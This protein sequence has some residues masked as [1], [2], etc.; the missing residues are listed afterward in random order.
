MKGG[1]TVSSRYITIQKLAED[2]GIDP[3]SIQAMLRKGLL[4]KYK[5]EGFGRVFIDIEEFDAKIQKDSDSSNND[6]MD[7][8]RFMVS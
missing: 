8:D 4:S 6:D 2:V 5:M 1:P 7:L 3:S